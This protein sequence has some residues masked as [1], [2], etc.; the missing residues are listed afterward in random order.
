[1]NVEGWLHRVGGDRVG[2]LQL[3]IEE[4]DTAQTQLDRSV[5]SISH[6]SRYIQQKRH[7]VVSRVV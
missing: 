4:G 2:G 3:Y 1:M 7:Q 6:L 5:S